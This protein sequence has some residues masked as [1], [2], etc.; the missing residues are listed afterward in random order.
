MTGKQVLTALRV[1]E[2]TAD[3]PVFVLTGMDPA[4]QN[5]GGAGPMAGAHFV[6]KPFDPEALVEE[7]GARWMKSVNAEVR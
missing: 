1:L 7:I 2:A 5:V 4:F 3:I 6:G